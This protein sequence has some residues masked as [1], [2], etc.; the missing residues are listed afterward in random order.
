MIFELGKSYI[1]SV[2]E[3]GIIP[4]LE[5]DNSQWY[6]KD[7]NDLDFLTEEEKTIVV[8]K[9]LDEI[10]AEIVELRSK[11]NVGVMECLDIIEKYKESECK[12]G[13]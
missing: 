9:V 11:Q 13:V 3:K 1:V 10:T 8:N 6:N 5:F 4:L 2:T 7:S 12:E